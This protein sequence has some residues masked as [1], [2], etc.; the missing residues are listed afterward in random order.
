MVRDLLPCFSSAFACNE[1]QDRKIVKKEGVNFDTSKSVGTT[2]PKVS[3]AL[4][5]MFKMAFTV[6]VIK[7]TD[8]L[9][10]T[11]AYVVLA[12]GIQAGI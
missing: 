4:S 1:L 2:S 3:K 10:Q 9:T 11:T 7:V 6:K 5:K 8:L 12:L